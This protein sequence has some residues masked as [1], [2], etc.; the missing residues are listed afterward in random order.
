MGAASRVIR[1][2]FIA[3]FVEGT[4][5]HAYDVACGGLHAYRGFPL[6]SQVLFQLLLVIDPLAAVL[7]WRRIPA[8]PLLGAAIMLADAAANWQGNWPSVRAD[9]G[10]LLRPYG[11]SMITLFGLF[12]LVT[13]LPLRRSLRAGRDAAHPAPA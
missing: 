12:V 4:C 3:G 9:P 13:A 8:A 7:A 1:F 5:A 2:I 11:L 10:L 6:V